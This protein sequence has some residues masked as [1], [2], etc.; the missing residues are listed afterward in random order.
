MNSS[1]MKR[2]QRLLAGCLA[3]LGAL[4]PAQAQ[5]WQTVYSSQPAAGVCGE[6]GVDATG[7]VYAAGRSIAPNGNSVAIL[8]RSG[9]QGATWTLLDQ[10]SEVGRSCAHN[11]AFAADLLRG[12]LFVGGNLNNLLPNGITRDGQGNILVGG[13][14]KD[15]A[16]VDYWIVRRLSP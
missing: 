14:A 7:N 16:G 13:T 10:F 6:M 11:R 1:E 8:Q 3:C 2:A 9:D 15:A 12:N 5:T 4:A